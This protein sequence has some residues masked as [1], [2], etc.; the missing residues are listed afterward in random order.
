MEA[1]L[2]ADTGYM[3]SDVRL[4]RQLVRDSL[5]VVDEGAVA[6]ALLARARVRATVARRQLAN[7][8]PEPIVRS[9]RRDPGARSFRLVRSH[10]SRGRR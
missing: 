9:F 4:L 8:R 7:E 5:Y 3:Q 10:A 2:G 1:A 6:D